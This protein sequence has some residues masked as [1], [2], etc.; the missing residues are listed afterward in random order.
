MG[1]K[2]STAVLTLIVPFL[3]SANSWAL[4][5]PRP[6]I[7][8][9][10][11]ANSAMTL[12]I[13]L[14]ESDPSALGFQSAHELSDY[15]IELG[16][17]IP[18]ITVPADI[19]KA[20]DKIGGFFEETSLFLYPVLVDNK[21]RSA[22]T[23]RKIEDTPADK[24]GWVHAFGGPGRPWAAEQLNLSHSAFIIKVPEMNVLYLGTLSGNEVTLYRLGV[25]HEKSRSTTDLPI[26]IGAKENA[27]DAL[28]KLPATVGHHH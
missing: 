14:V 26:S 7:E 12:L 6:P 17:V 13:K 19:L 18:V 27:R 28:S 1:V 16:P 8:A 11:A 9:Q 23:V 20:Y 4:E 3:F 21:V 5:I 15:K 2:A 24:G 22:I 25:D 10:A